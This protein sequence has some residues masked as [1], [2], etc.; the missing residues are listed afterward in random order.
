MQDIAEFTVHH[1]EVEP[2][3]KKLLASQN[4]QLPTNLLGQSP[5]SNH[6]HSNTNLS[7][8]LPKS[9]NRESVYGSSKGSSRNVIN[10]EPQ[11]ESMSIKAYIII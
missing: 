10:I 7:E 9:T 5:G 3:I 1:I 6:S 2:Y 11:F 8:C 4:I